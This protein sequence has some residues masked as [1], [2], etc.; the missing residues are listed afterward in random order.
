VKAFI[1]FCVSR[2]VTVIM[3]LAALFMGALFSL[4]VL[5][6]DRLPELRA[7]RVTVETLYPGMGAGDIRSILTIPVEDALS[8]VKGLER[9][10]SISRDGSSVICLDFRWGTDP[11]AAAVLVREAIDAVYPAL[12]E[13]VGKPMVVPGDPDAEPHGIIA[14]CSRNG[15]AVFARDLAEYELRSR[16]R[17][18]DGVGTVILV[19]GESAEERIRL[20]IPRLVSRGLDAPAFARLLSGE[21]ADVPAG[22]AREGDTELVVV[23]SGR[24]ATGEELAALIL[25]AGGGALNISDAGDV[26]RE[27]SR[28]KSLFVFDGREGTALEIYRRP[29]A[30]PVKLSRDI[31]KLLDEARPL[32]DRDAEIVLVHDSSKTII[33]GVWNLC[34]SALLGTLAVTATLIFFIRRIRWGLLTALSIPVS[35]SAGICALALSGR[36]LNGMSLGGLAMGIGLVSDAGVIVLDLLHRRF[37]NQS[38]R[39]LPEELAAA[40]ASVAGSSLAS[41]ITTAVVFV[42]VIFLPGPLGSLFGDTSIALVTSIAAGW[43]Y[44][45]FCLP[46]LYRIF[47]QRPGGRQTNPAA[48]KRKPENWYSPL[49]AAGLRNPRKVLAAAV[50]VCLLG[51][52][53]LLTRPAAFISPDEAEELEVSL[54]FPPGTLLE[55]AGESGR[56][57]SRSLLELPGVQ[58]VFGRAGSEDEDL[59]RRA[60]TDY[61]KEELRFRCILAAGADPEKTL[62]EIREG[63]E[64][65]TEGSD[66]P[67]PPLPQGTLFSAALPQ[68]RTERLLG[69]SSA[70]T[71]AVRG[72]GRDETAGRAGDAAA[73]LRKTLGPSLASLHIRPSGAR[74]ELR[75]FP[76]REASAFLGISAAAAAE[77]LYTITEGV[78][79]SQLEIDGRPLD[80]RVSGKGLALEPA[81]EPEAALASFPLL[82][83]RGNRVFLGSLGRVE[84]REAEAALARLDRG[85]VI[86]LDLL[87]LSGGG[88]GFSA[89]IQ[90]AASGLPWLSRAG[91]S[92]F[93][94]YRFS[95]ILT[96]ILVLILLYMTMGAQFE[97][98]LLPLILMLAIPFSL[99]GAGSA[100]FLCGAGLDSG[101]ALGLSVLFGLVVNNGIILYEIG[102]EKI[103]AG[104]SPGGAVFSGARERFRP[105]LITTITT[106]LALL[107]LM[108]AP[109]GSAQRSMAAA[110]T[111]GIISAALLSFFALPPVF[112]RF[113]R[114]RFRHE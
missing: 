78:V 76:D 114:W 68:D 31:N 32:F 42:P 89:G 30:D 8:P 102:E 43:L 6:L 57:L 58:S 50:P 98:F 70:H 75:F 91:E 59:G 64:I 17:R 104:L 74:P 24:P 5:P 23:S 51:A 44:A 111:G 106:V 53:L 72:I 35:A 25:P 18:I 15:D 29:G 61:R 36:S 34:I 103:R 46:S 1:V 37:Q 9:I 69:L 105:V 20:D 12:P 45:Q 56:A 92:A 27:R 4:S 85:D 99:A 108:I 100:L 38:Q 11:Q 60:D 86:Y 22:N 113:F 63:L 28:R 3:L 94:R 14:V 65:F 55:S 93:T 73:R 41:T 90:K 83:P 77:A 88:K 10:R 2:P 52:S 84:R 112:I 87:P 16:L 48:F 79:C 26:G 49:L 67:G 101:A 7:P 82:G 13:G 97:S 19:G 62:D 80:V 95:L 54:V 71:L 110:M 33:R 96:L 40:A 47:F 81:T 107:P 21:T 66:L 109:L 39:P